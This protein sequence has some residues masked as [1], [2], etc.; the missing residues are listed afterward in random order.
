MQHKPNIF[1]QIDPKAEMAS[2]ERGIADA[3]AGRVIS[4]EAVK[5]W[6]LSWGTGKRLP[7]P[8]IGD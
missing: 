5:K 3:G 8:Q 2:L 6:L 1:E 4:H 7:R